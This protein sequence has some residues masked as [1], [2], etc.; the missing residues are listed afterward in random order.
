M[1]TASYAVPRLEPR[2]PSPAWPPSGRAP[3]LSPTIA[4]LG[5]ERL[6]PV[7]CMRE[8][9]VMVRGGA[10]GRLYRFEH[11]LAQDVPLADARLLVAEGDFAFSGGR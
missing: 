4:P 1:T 8:E 6:I 3:V 5:S 2:R 11:G 7:R 9:T 10:T